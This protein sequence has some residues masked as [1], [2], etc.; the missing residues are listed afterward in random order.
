[1]T[2]LPLRGRRRWP[3]ARAVR[4]AVPVP[5]GSHTRYMLASYCLHTFLVTCAI[6]TIALSIDSTL[7]LS[8]VVATISTWNTTWTAFYVAWYIVLRATDFLAEL[9]PL[10]CFLGAFWTEIAHTLSRERLVVWLSG[11]TPWQCML[12]AL[13]FGL[14]VGGAQLALNRYLRPNAVMMMARDHLGSYG[15]QFDPR[16]LPYPQWFALGHD[17]VQAFVEPGDPA[18][19]R[20]VKIYRMDDSLSLWAFIRAKSAFPVGRNEWMLVEGY[21]WSSPQAPDQHSFARDDPR[22]PAMTEQIPFASETIHLDLS[23]VWLNNN[24]VGARYLTSDVFAALGGEDFSPAY[25]FRTWRHVRWSLALFCAAMPLLATSLSLALI[26][27]R[28]AFAPLLTIAIAGYAANTLMKVS[29]LLGEHGYVHP[30][31]AA[32]LVPMLVLSACSMV[33]LIRRND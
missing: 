17:I 8:K 23:P 21:R 18:S 1:V 5:F 10:A 20:D 29:A 16:P 11:R 6:L 19:L 4:R 28:I 15:E 12:P 31:V 26:A 25:E 22:P 7:F 3:L 14:I 24:R 27:K 32:W 2:T 30:A 9:L 13:L 33:G